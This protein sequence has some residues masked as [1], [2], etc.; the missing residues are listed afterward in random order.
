MIIAGIEVPWE[1]GGSKSEGREILKLEMSAES[2]ERNSE[3]G[4]A[5]LSM[6]EGVS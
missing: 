6:P 3:P 5:C 4:R 1:D 2:F